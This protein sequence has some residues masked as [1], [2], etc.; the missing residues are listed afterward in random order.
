MERG[1]LTQRFQNC[2]IWNHSTIRKERVFRAFSLWQGGVDA[3]RRQAIQGDCQSQ[4][5]RCVVTNSNLAMINSIRARIPVFGSIQHWITREDYEKP[6]P[7]PECYLKAIAL[8]GK[9][10][11]RIIGFEDSVRGLTSLEADAGFACSDMSKTSSA[12]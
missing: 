12:S 6:K 9:K 11:D 3:W 4:D 7:D 5:S 1:R 2:P 10:G 8:Y